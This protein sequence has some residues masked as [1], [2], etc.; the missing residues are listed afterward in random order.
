MKYQDKFIV[1]FTN[2][3]PNDFHGSFKVKARFSIRFNTIEAANKAA[4]IYTRN[5][6]KKPYY[7]EA[8]VY[9]GSLIV[10]PVHTC[11][12]AYPYVYL[13]PHLKYIK[14]NA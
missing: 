7:K 2:E 8:T 6:P 14:V 10:C 4:E 5:Q 12:I 9:N 1:S 11:Y 3:V 13:N